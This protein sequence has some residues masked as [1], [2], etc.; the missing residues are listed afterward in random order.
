LLSGF[1]TLRQLYSGMTAMAEDKELVQSYV[2]EGSDQ[3]FRALVGRHVDLV[4]ATALRQVGDPGTA[5]EITQNV[6]LTLAQKAP[7]LAGVETLAGWLHRTAL[8]EA[9]AHIRAELRRRQ[10]EERAVELASLQREGED[11][12]PLETMA[13]LLDEG[14]LNLR[15]GDRLALILRFLENRS[16]RDV[17]L[18]F[19]IDEDAA[20]KR[21]SRALDRL[22]DFFRDRGF[23]AP[24]AAG[25]ATV[26]TSAAK[27]A[28]AGLAAS[29]ANAGLAAG[30]AVG[31]LNLFLFQVMSL[32]KTQ[33]TLG[34]LL[35]ALAPFAWQQQAEA[36][37]AA[38]R[39]EVETR[40]SMARGA[41]AEL[42]AETQRLR[43]ALATSQAELAA[44]ELRLAALA[45]HTAPGAPRPTYQWDDNS[46][47]VRIPKGL[48]R[49]LSLS[50]ASNRRGQ[51]TDQIQE[52]LQMTRAEQ[53]A[54]EAA[55]GQFLTE[56]NAA[57]AQTLRVIP[58]TPPDLDG[59]KPDEV[60]VFEVSTP[61]D[62][63]A[64][65]RR[66]LFS[67]LEETLGGERFTLFRDALKNW[68]PVDDEF[69][70]LN[71]SLAVMNF[72]HRV[73]FLKPNPGDGRLGWQIHK[74][75]GMI[76]FTVEIE[77]IPPVFR[78]HLQD[79]I[80]LARSQPAANNK[81]QP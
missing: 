10:R 27:A 56:V 29:A 20:R 19:G 49:E 16:L 35:L 33:I 80:E 67:R 69:G 24:A 58:P 76:S 41:A 26:L 2:A 77:D 51:L 46:P 81:P 53:Q 63:F 79:W 30:G 61:T 47:Y 1:A 66:E 60:R 43:N 39:D 31:G 11:L 9:K 55:L 57:Q 54:V 73:H 37:L 25:C 8:F 75:G 64:E 32:T 28:P 38:Q 3:A 42:D 7:W 15:E 71:S 6:F 13:P 12:S 72:D 22:A 48:I 62:R 18:A 17:G 65:L 40:L 70:G 50:A 52:A 44:A 74:E 4:Y 59:R 34:C 21:V 78:P 68:M 14:L 5:E 45:S 23:V 36:R